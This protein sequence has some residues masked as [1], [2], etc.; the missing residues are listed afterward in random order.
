MHD[1]SCCSCLTALLPPYQLPDPAFC[2]WLLRRCCIS[3]V[4][5]TLTPTLALTLAWIRFDREKRVLINAMP[6]RARCNRV[7]SDG[8]YYLTDTRASR[9]DMYVVSRL[10]TY[11][12]THGHGKVTSRGIFKTV[13]RRAP[14]SDARIQTISE[15]SQQSTPSKCAGFL[16][17][18]ELPD[19]SHV[20]GVPRAV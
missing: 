8:N 7:E 12:S 4:A 18:A 13:C 9:R 6:T 1:A 17:R 14:I 20:S 5:L 11:C 2:S 15:M 16:T 10:E 19:R 3:F